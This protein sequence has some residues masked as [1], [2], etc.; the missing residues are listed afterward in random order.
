VAFHATLTGAGWQF[1]AALDAQVYQKLLPKLH[2][3]ERRLGPVLKALGE[4][5]TLHG[6][7]ASLE[8]I[9]R[10]QDRLKDGFTSFAEA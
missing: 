6:C 5:C 7:T 9:K 3:S 4:F 10:M 1:S 2:G 8:K